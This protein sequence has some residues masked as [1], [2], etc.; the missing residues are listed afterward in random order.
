MRPLSGNGANLSLGLEVDVEAAVPVDDDAASSPSLGERSFPP[1]DEVP[2]DAADD[3]EVD[4]LAD[5]A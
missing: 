5:V 3:N 2:A 1:L 4:L